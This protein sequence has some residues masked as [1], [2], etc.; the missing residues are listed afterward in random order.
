VGDRH[1]PSLLVALPAWNLAAGEV[2]QVRW[3]WSGGGVA[4]RRRTR[5]WAR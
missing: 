5:P 4:T 2:A 1:Q 3:N